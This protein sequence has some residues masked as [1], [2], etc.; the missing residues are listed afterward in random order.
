[1]SIESG[2]EMRGTWQDDVAFRFA[3]SEDLSDFQAVN[4]P[5]EKIRKDHYFTSFNLKKRY[6]YYVPR[7]NRLGEG[8]SDLSARNIAYSGIWEPELEWAGLG[9]NGLP[10]FSG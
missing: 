4:L 9:R 3:F 10:F 2:R 8:A 5:E 1:M 7:A 6:T